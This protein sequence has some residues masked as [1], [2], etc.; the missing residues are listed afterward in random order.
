MAMEMRPFIWD[1]E[2]KASFPC[3]H[4]YAKKLKQKCESCLCHTPQQQSNSKPQRRGR[5]AIVSPNAVL[6]PKDLQGLL[7]ATE[8]KLNASVQAVIKSP[9]LMS[10]I[11]KILF[12]Q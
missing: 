3:N 6:S 11:Y 8:Q 4:F 1:M 9:Y 7:Q 12:C 2:R 10:Q 5:G